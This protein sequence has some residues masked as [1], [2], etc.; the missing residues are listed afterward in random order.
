MFTTKPQSEAGVRMIFRSVMHLCTEVFCASMHG[1]ASMHKS[2]G[3]VFFISFGW[4]S[5]MYLLLTNIA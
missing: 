5:C 1:Y 4:S 2:V 3:E